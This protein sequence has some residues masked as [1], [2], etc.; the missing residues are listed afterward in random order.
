MH[1]TEWLHFFE[2]PYPSANMV[3]IRSTRPVLI[4]SGFGSDVTTTEALLQEVGV[5]PQSL[6]LIANTHYH[7]DHVGGNHALQQRHTIPIAAHRWDMAMINQRD[8]E[9]CS[10]EWLNQP[11]EFYQIN[12]PLSDGDEIDAGDVKLQVLHTPGHTLGHL[13]YYEPHEQ[14]L[15]CGDTFHRDDVA[16]LNIFREGAG[17]IQRMQDTLDRLA[18]LPIR[19]A[20]S[21][22]GPAMDNP[23][24]SLDAARRRYDKWFA[25]PEKLAWHAC[26]RIFTYALML[27]N[28]MTFGQIEQYLL[29]SPWFHDYTRYIFKCEPADFIQPLIDETL[30]ARA[31][32]WQKER[33]MPITPYT[34]LPV[35]WPQ[36]PTRPVDW[37]RMIFAL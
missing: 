29:A 31:T 20:Y 13:A 3:L 28:G 5:P 11:I 34:P 10:A 23:Q 6:A 15:I 37:P 35:G 26:K 32:A 14:I 19:Y 17:V 27:C 1:I 16:W 12:I 9:T 24:A 4:D 33:L 18:R 30:R 21:G 7:G 8:R 25:D 22:H 2:R 36:G